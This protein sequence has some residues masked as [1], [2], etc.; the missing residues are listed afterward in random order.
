MSS[1]KKTKGNDKQPHDAHPLLLPTDRIPT[2]SA[3]RKKDAR[4]ELRMHLDAYPIH[5]LAELTTLSEEALG[6]PIIVSFG[7]E[8]QNS[9][10]AVNKKVLD[11]IEQAL[12]GK[13]DAELYHSNVCTRPDG[14]LYVRF[15]LL[16]PAIDSADAA[17]QL[18]AALME[19]NGAGAFSVPT[20]LST[21]VMHNLGT[22]PWKIAVKNVE[23]APPGWYE[24]LKKG[25]IFHA[26]YADFSA[27]CTAMKPNAVG[28]A[29]WIKHSQLVIDDIPD[30]YHIF[31]IKG[32]FAFPAVAAANS[33][34][35][36][37]AT[38]V[39]INGNN[40]MNGAFIYH[41]DN[42]QAKS[43]I[44]AIVNQTH[45]CAKQAIRFDRAKKAR[46]KQVQSIE[47]VKEQLEFISNNL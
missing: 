18:S 39:N 44:L 43:V 9:H 11:Y 21:A 36:V 12:S 28:L 38:R 25:D 17:R 3:Q 32:K 29:G 5:P 27:V 10:A 47:R 22:V 30:V 42:K 33:E 15:F 19:N 14:T 46:E 6:K 34:A 45:P 35:T 4:F 7:H 13:L 2:L 16:L 24:C 8:L 37:L 20:G 26:H 40:L 1:S 41:G 23:D 31:L